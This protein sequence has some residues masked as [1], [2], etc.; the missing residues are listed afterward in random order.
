VAKALTHW[1]VLSGLVHISEI[2]DR[3]VKD[4]H[5]FLSE[6]QVVSVKVFAIDSEGRLKLSIKRLGNSPT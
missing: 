6:G 3:F 1:S 5:S 2:S 4:V